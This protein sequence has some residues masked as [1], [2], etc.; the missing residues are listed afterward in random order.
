[1]ID[2]GPHLWDMQ[3]LTLQH[4]FPVLRPGGVYIIEDLHTSFG[5]EEAKLHR[6]TSE[7]STFA[8]IQSLL[9]GLTGGQGFAANAKDDFATHFATQAA[10]VTLAASTAPAS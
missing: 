4:L 8:Y 10:S 1:M 3:I 6:G 7:V 9:P 2:D 5:P